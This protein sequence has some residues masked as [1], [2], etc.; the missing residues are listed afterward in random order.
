[1]AHGR[2]GQRQARASSRHYRGGCGAQEKALV[3]T[4]FRETTAPLAAFLGS[5]FGRA[6][7]VCTAKR[8][9]GSAGNW[10]AGS[11]R[12]DNVPFFVLSLKAGGAGLNLHGSFAC[13]PFRPMV[14]SGCGKP[15]Y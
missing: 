14:E 2:G 10:C 4:Q 15:G 5:V 6:G 1:M 11:R 8:R 7:L 12:N 9:S 3:F 13:H